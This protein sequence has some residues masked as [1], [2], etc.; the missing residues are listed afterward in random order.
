MFLQKVCNVELCKMKLFQNK[1]RIDTCRLKGWN[2]SS[3]G[4]YFIT[5]C[6]H[7]RQLIFGEIKNKKMIL[8][9]RGNI[10]KKCW[11]DLPNHYPNLILDAFVVMPN[12]IH[13]IMII[14]NSVFEKNEIVETGLKPVSTSN[15][16]QHGIF[17]FVRALKTFSSRKINEIDN[18][19]GKK[20]WQ[21]RFYDHIIRN[22]KEM[23]RI[24]HRLLHKFQSP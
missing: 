9:H 8:N 15:Q 17:E 20:Q 18:T 10:V 5:I 14:D 1:Y 3:N 24:L 11:F 21:S 19:K 4:A 2:Y 13:G 12:H 23:Q 6:V 7:D 22:E 16:K